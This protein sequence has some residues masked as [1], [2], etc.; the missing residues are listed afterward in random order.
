MT[1]VLLNIQ[2][3]PTPI[4]DRQIHRHVRNAAGKLSKQSPD[5]NGRVHLLAI[6]AVRNIALY[7]F[8]PCDLRL[9]STSRGR[10]V[11]GYQRTHPVHSHISTHIVR[12]QAYAKA[13]NIAFDRPQTCRLDMPIVHRTTGK[14]PR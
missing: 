13:K 6:A 5:G 9:Q 2:C 11:T 8:A 1:T 7:Q 12:N 3:C 10:L 4:K 14:M